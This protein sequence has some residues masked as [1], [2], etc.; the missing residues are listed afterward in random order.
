MATECSFSG[1]SRIA[2][3]RELIDRFRQWYAETI[4][5]PGSFF[6]QVVNWLFKQNQIAQ[7]RFVALGQC[8]DLAQVRTP[9]CLLAASH[10][11]VVSMDQLFAV[12][13]LVGTPAE[14]LVKMTAPGGH[15]SLFLGSNVLD[16][17][18]RDIVGWLRRDLNE[19]QI[20]HP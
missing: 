14:Q 7:G 5:L 8:I 6:L 11:E 2:Q 20:G 19:P 4:D 15:L 12:A 3:R 16:G 17:A 1:A 9:I 18:W 10:D 13:R